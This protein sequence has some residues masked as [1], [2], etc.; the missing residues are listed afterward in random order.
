M[1]FLDFLR[2]SDII[3]TIREINFMQKELVW[4]RYY[5]SPEPH[6]FSNTAPYYREV[7][8]ILMKSNVFP[9]REALHVVMGG[10]KGARSAREFLTFFK[11]LRPDAHDHISFLDMNFFPLQ[12]HFSSFARDGSKAIQANLDSL[13]LGEA[14]VDLIFFDFTPDFMDKTTTQQAFN[15]ARRALRKDGLIIVACENT[16]LIVEAM[17]RDLAYKIKFGVPHFSK[18]LASY[19]QAAKISTLTPL[20]TG[21]CHDGAA[22]ILVLSP[23]SYPPF[24]LGKDLDLERFRE[25]SVLETTRSFRLV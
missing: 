16:S 3:K 25:E 15:E 4:Q 12:Q 11:T 8:N 9:G 14:S 5:Q 10:L 21:S 23:T 17:S 6:T 7:V 24:F 19:L 2:K 1:I 13:P 18:T 22:D 20:L